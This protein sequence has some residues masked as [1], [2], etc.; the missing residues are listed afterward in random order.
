M[1]SADHD[2][3]SQDHDC[4]VIALLRGWQDRSAHQLAVRA[5]DVEGWR[6]T[7]KPTVRSSLTVSDLWEQVRAA[8][9]G[10]RTMGV[11]PGSTVA[12]QVPNWCESHVAFLATTAVGGVVMPISTIYRGRDLRRQLAVGEA[13]T[14]VVPGRLGRR[15]Y[16]AEAVEL[17]AG[18]ELRHLNRV[19]TLGTEGHVGATAW[20]DL[21]SAGGADDLADLREQIGR[22]AFVPGLHELLLLNFTSGTTGEPKGVMHTASTV[23]ASGRALAER[24]ELTADDCFFVPATL[25][26]AAGFL[27]GLY[28]PLSVGAT[29]VFMDGWDVELA[30]RVIETERVTYGPAIPTYLIDISQ[31]PALTAHDIS[32]WSRVRVSGGSIPR[33][34]LVD[35][36]DRLPSLRLCPGWGMSEV[37]YATGVAPDDPKEKLASSDGRPLASAQLEVRD[38]QTG[39]Q[40]AVREIGE[41]VVRGGS[42]TPGYF[43]R[44]NLTA[45]ALSEDGWLRSGDLGFLDEDG[46]LT[47]AGRSKE[48]V[49]RGGENVPVVE[50][51]HLLDSHPAVARAAVIGVPDDRL[52]EKVCAVIELVD[53]SQP[54]TIDDMR[55][56]LTN[57][58]LTKQFLPEY[59]E[60]VPVLPRTSLGKLR[61]AALKEEIV[62]RYALRMS[63]TAPRP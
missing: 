26:H 42:V 3:P 52:G 46:F 50:V 51:E 16:G 24:L 2:P 63:Q 45:A 5:Y 31:H 43:H 47:I 35:L 15:A 62:P 1:R 13:A 30:L 6:T 37:L 36:Q 18:G 14:L 28:V 49:I 60:Y 39:R 61:K 10:L 38:Q 22:S 33:H 17:L 8:A 19:I 40:C 4:D 34:V 41:I 23:M 58:G 55:A 56:F 44:D 32:S 25:G 21:L 27:N 7:N 54:F 57:L 29:T 12:L 11:T 59:L 20:A 53:G 48:L 9:A